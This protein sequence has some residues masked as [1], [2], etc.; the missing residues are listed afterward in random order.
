MK[1]KINSYLQVLTKP[2]KV[3]KFIE[4]NTLFNAWPGVTKIN[5]WLGL[6]LYYPQVKLGITSQMQEYWG[7]LSL[8]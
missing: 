8:I 3:V 4:I 7:T 2:F 5:R 1:E 6:K